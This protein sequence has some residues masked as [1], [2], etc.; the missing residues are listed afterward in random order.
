MRWA[1]DDLEP[2]AGFFRALADETRLRLVALLTH[3]ELC[4][5]HLQDA[6]RLSQPT[7]SRQLRILK[8]AGIVRA[9]KLGAWTYYALATQA[10]ARRRSHLRALVASF[11]ADPAL[12]RA[13]RRL[14]DG[15]GPLKCR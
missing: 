10:D 3:G 11:A 9:R 14:Q 8:A 12:E 4:V 13:V 1:D 5:C 15:K 7:A 6:L 2:L